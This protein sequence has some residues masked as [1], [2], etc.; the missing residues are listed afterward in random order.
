MSQDEGIGALQGDPL[1]VRQTILNL[2]SNACKF[3]KQGRVSVWAGRESL[4]VRE[5]VRFEVQDT[6]VGIAPE[7]M[8]KIF[9]EFSQ[10][11]GREGRADGTG[12][13]LAISR[14]LCRLMGG[15][16]TERSTVG[17]GSTIVARLP[18]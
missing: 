10:V 5:W 8:S 17:K 15:E 7:D 13:G 6:G 2:A 9:G 12:L 16:L 18:C 4:D 3:T 14:R 11:G 1:R